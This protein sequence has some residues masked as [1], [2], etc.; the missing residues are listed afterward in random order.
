M[1][2]DDDDEVVR[3]LDVH[4]CNDFAAYGTQLCL[5]QHPLRP[6]WR[7]Y[8][9]DSVQAVRIK[10]RAKRIEVDLPLDTRSANYCDE[11]EDFKKIK[12]FT[13]RSTLTEDRT[14]LAVGTIKGGR[15][16]IA[17]LDYAL[18]LRPSLQHLN[19][20]A[21]QQKKED[22]DGADLDEEDDE[23]KMH[24]VEVQV[25]KR[26]TERQA[27]ARK[28]SYAYISQ[29]EE[30]EPFVSLQVHSEDSAAAHGVWAKLMVPKESEA[31]TK[32]DRSAYLRAIVPPPSSAAAGAAGSAAGGEP[33]ADAGHGA[34]GK[35][36]L[37][38]AARAALPGAVQALFKEHSVCSMANV[39]T[40]LESSPAAA[41]A[42]E[43]AYLP[44]RALHEAVL[45]LGTVSSMHRV[46]VLAKTGDDKTD[47]VR[48]LLLD[49]LDRKEHF[50][51]SE[52]N[53]LA[54]TNSVT[55]SEALYN[56]VIKEICESKGNTWH[57]K[58]CATGL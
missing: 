37:S 18:Q 57:I 7:P 42:K 46:Y 30:E 53:D 21:A 15:L 35:D 10:P 20:A 38:D 3:E 12:H 24:A 51:R 27:Q 31:G 1:D 17:P 39:R 49:L 52:F 44:D 11:V 14:T 9:Y 45:A 22:A 50:K 43:A 34:A 48:K 41:A 58:T 28:N 5:M 4:V 33:G 13:L 56:K 19:V 2:D 54:R 32:L 40:W 6:P 36:V 16:L 26:E 25:Q 29:Q 47:P 55:F 23:P 8:D